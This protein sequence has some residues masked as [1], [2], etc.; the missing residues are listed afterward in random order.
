MH[1][2]KLQNVYNVYNITVV[3][4]SSNSQLSCWRWDA[5]G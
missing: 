5:P 3:V 2:R 4:Y 1:Y